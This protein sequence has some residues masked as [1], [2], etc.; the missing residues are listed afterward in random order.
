LTLA[1]FGDSHSIAILPALDKIG[2]ERAEKYTHIGLGGCPPFIN[3]DVMKGNW[4]PKVCE[5]LSLKQYNFVKENNIKNILLVGMWT[6]YTEGN[7]NNSGIFYLVSKK[8]MALN[9][10]TSRINFEIAMKETIESYQKLG[11]NVYMLAQIPIQKVDGNSLYPKIYFFNVKDKKG[12]INSQSISK[13]EHLK[14][15]KFNRDV[16]VKLR[17]ELKFTYINLDNDFCDYEKCYLGS[18]LSSKY[19]DANHVSVTGAL[20]L[21]NSLNSYI[22]TKH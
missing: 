17:N 13:Y 21:Y 14:L 2:K 3:V 20:S 11:V 6:L 19:T 22:K 4:K 9:M 1:I 15:Q 5:T 18:D 10:E 7:Y 12:V 16:I 8:Y